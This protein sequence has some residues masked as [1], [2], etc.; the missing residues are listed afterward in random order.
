MPKKKYGNEELERDVGTA[1]GAND[2][3]VKLGSEAIDEVEKKRKELAAKVSG[4]FKS[5]TTKP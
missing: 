2:P 5:A 4:W 1:G 3:L